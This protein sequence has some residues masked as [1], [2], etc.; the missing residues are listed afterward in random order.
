MPN[1]INFDSNFVG[2]G[3]A[4]QLGQRPRLGEFILNGSVYAPRGL[5]NIG[6]GTPGFTM[7]GMLVGDAINIA[8]GPGQ[9]WT[10]NGPTAGPSSWRLYR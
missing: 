9:P 5:I 4:I 1:G 8:I 2:A 3:N 7:T 10:F 6:T